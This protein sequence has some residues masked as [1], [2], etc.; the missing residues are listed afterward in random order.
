MEFIGGAEQR[1]Q[2]DGLCR[3]QLSDDLVTQV[4]ESTKEKIV[5]H[6]PS[7]NQSDNQVEP[8]QLMGVIEDFIPSP[9]KVIEGCDEDKDEDTP[10]KEEDGHEEVADV[11]FA[12]VFAWGSD[13]VGMQGKLVQKL[14]QTAP[15]GPPHPHVKGS[16]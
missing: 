3:A 1:N 2:L 6:R 14:A 7:M 9:S 5:P 16:G 11:A 15:T 4:Q 12:D 13:D 10:G 8:S